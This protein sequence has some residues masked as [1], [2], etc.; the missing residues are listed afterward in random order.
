[1]ETDWLADRFEAQRPQLLGL[2]YRMLASAS[3]AEG[4]VQTTLASHV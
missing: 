4:A 1:M 2:A 3:D